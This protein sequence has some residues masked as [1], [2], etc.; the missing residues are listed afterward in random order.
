MP[1]HT[2]AEHTRVLRFILVG[3]LAAAVHWLAVVLLVSRWGWPPVLANVPAWAVALGVSFAGH[4]RWTF[5]GH[6]AAPGRAF[7]R[8]FVV[9]A[10]AFCLNEAA[11]ALL[12]HWSRMHYG[13]L[14]ALVLAGVA[15]LTYL[16][17]RHWAFLRTPGA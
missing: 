15:A 16:A 12:L 4:H 2:R 14:L 8:F 13:L 1:V 7:G 5:G 11:Y 10:A 6:G 17:N 9:S 3:G